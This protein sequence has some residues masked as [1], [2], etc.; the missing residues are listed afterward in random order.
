MVATQIRRFS[1]LRASQHS[2]GF[3]KTQHAAAPVRSRRPVTTM[4]GFIGSETNLII[5]GCTTLCLVAGRV[6][7]APSA[8][9]RASAGLNLTEVPSGMK[10]GDPAGFTAVDV[11]AHGTFG[12]IIGVGIVLGL[13]SIGSL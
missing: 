8:N 7:L 1:G 10:T 6:G 13:K 11:L 9:R 4:A 5:C 3:V 2:S 12:H